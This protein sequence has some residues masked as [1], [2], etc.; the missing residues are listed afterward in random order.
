MKSKTKKQKN[1]KR[2][3]P[4]KGNRV[5]GLADAGLSTLELPPADLAFP[6]D[7]HWKKQPL[8]RGSE[9]SVECGEVGYSI[10]DE[11]DSPI[12]NSRLPRKRRIPI[13]HV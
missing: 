13:N 11:Q 9:E 3:N 12:T 8:P 2:N 1:A 4:I 5:K 10:K 6:P 7:Q